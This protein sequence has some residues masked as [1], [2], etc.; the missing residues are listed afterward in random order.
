MTLMR[1]GT[2][3]C[4]IVGLPSNHDTQKGTQ[5]NDPLLYTVPQ[6]ARL[7]SM[8]RTAVYELLRTGQLD[9][10]KIGSMRRVPA[11]AVSEFVG[12]LEKSR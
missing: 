6:V 7:L 12:N 11:T 2:N 3:F 10:V 4:V 5:M 1:T 9:S 8:G